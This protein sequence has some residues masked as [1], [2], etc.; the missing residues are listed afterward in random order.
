M[1]FSIYDVFYPQNSHQHVSV[2]IP[3]I[4]RVTLIQE[5]KNTNV[6][7][8]W[9]YQSIVIKIIILVRII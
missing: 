6:V 2:S 1:H 4:L 3:V 7:K 8:S 5:Y 9:H